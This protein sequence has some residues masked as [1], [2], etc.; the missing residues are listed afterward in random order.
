MLF[1]SAERRCRAGQ[2]DRAV[3][4]GAGGWNAGIQALAGRREGCRDHGGDAAA[5]GEIADD[6]HS[7]WLA[8]LDE[9]RAAEAISIAALDAGTLR[10][11]RQG[12]LSD[13]KA[14]ASGRGA[15]KGVF[16]VQMVEA[17][18]HAPERVFEGKDG[19]CERVSGPLTIDTAAPARLPL[20]LIKQYPTQIFIQGLIELAGELRS[21]LAGRNATSIEIALARQP[22]EMLGGA[23]AGHAAL[24][25]ETADHSPGFAIAAILDRKSTR[26][27]SS[28]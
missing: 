20:T 18:C 11:V 1:R 7:A 26:L 16:A 28:H 10:S 24:N 9:G 5:R 13:W 23:S 3:R 27:N 22:V 25:R 21:Q 12:K 19:F 15:S 4:S 2:G 14:I 8:G 6:R 17:G